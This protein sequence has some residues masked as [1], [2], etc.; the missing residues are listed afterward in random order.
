MHVTCV[1]VLKSSQFNP[2]DAGGKVRMD[3]LILGCEKKQSFVPGNQPIQLT[4]RV[5]KKRV[6]HHAWGTQGLPTR[7]D[8]FEGSILELPF[9]GERL[10]QHW[11]GSYM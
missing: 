3:L 9:G 11:R 4:F 7:P 8:D 6:H 10:M 2:G 1:I 5:G